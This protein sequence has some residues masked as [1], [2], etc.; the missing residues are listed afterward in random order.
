MK[1]FFIGV[2]G[3]IIVVAIIFGSFYFAFSLNDNW[4]KHE[5]ATIEITMN[6]DFDGH[7]MNTLWNVAEYFCP[8]DVDKQ[9]YI[10]MVEKLN[11]KDASELKRYETIK[12][13]I[14]RA[15]GAE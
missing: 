6:C 12:I 8:D 11:N 3:L 10:D 5:W 13:Y 4:D 1:N 2:F 7:N 14:A 15:E 9:Q